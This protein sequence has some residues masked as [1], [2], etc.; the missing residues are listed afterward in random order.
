MPP[1]PQQKKSFF[2]EKKVSQNRIF[3]LD[4]YG[5]AGGRAP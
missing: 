5:L 2:A 1:I 4:S 3:F